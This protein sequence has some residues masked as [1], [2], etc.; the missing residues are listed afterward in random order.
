MAKIVL[1]RQQLAKFRR[2]VPGL[3]VDQELARRMG[4]DPGQVSR[5][6]R[7]ASPGPKFIAGILDVFGIEFF[8]DLFAVVPDDDGNG[9]AA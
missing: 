3:D 9:E 4:M 7:G 5:V 6:L 2:L 1:R 8:Q